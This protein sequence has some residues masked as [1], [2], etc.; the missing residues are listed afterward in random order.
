MTTTEEWRDVVDFENSYTV[1]SLGRIKAKKR[2]GS[3][4]GILKSGDSSGYPFV[5]LTVKGRAY[6]RRIHS[7]VARSFL[8]ERPEDCEVNHVDGDKSNNQV[9]NLEYITHQQNMD[10]AMVNG[11]KPKG[12][13][14]R[15]PLKGERAPGAKLRDADIAEIRAKLARKER[16][17]AIAKEFG[18]SDMTISMIKTGKSWSHV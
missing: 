16:G 1:S 10:H 8:G 9:S 12:Y 4:G 13:T 7:L 3:R 17:A 5:I 14:N 15:N 6:G 2:K 11:L 18:V